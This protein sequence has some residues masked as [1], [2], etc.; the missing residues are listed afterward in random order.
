[1]RYRWLVVALGS[2]MAVAG[3]RGSETAP[4]GDE[5]PVEGSRLLVTDRDGAVWSVGPDDGAT[6]RL[7][8][9]GG[10][11]VVQA[12]S[13]G[14]GSTVVW[15]RIVDGEPSVAVH[16]G[17]GVSDLAVPTPPFFY[18]FAPGDERLLALGNDP[19]GRGVALLLIDPG[20]GAVDTVDVGA[21]YYV[22]W[23]PD[24]GRVAA[25]VGATELATVSL[26][27]ERTSLPVRTGAFQAPAW[28]ADG[29][30]VAVVSSEG[31]T[32]SLAGQSVTSTL[33]LVDV[34]TAEAEPLVEVSSGVTFDLSPDGTRV[35]YVDG[36]GGAGTAFG[37]LAVVGPGPDHVRVADDVVAFE[38]SPDGGRLLLLTLHPDDGLV[39]HLWDGSDLVDYAGFVPTTTFLTQYLPFWSQYVQTIT[40][41][42]PDGSAFAFARAA[43]EGEDGGT[44]WVQEVDGERR[45]VVDGEMV[46]WSP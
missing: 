27:G 7:G 23:A 35:A 24:A 37:S 22:S 13:S 44:V 26:E 9:S 40:A 36:V 32:A 45:D 21:P 34:E 15:T 29:R 4:T 17:E 19:D 30:L 1:M 25:H 42:A 38:W 31:A 8:D 6:E 28:S 41:W 46:V 11:P 12:T 3:C 5:A 43:E 39:P 14:D 16:D 10:A 2:L 18:M 20:G 33:A